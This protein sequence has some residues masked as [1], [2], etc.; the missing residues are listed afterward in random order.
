MED[1]LLEVFQ[2]YFSGIEKIKFTRIT[3]GHIHDTFHIE[4]GGGHIIQRINTRVFMDID[5]MMHNMML[6]SK[7][8]TGHRDIYPMKV[9]VLHQTLAGEPYYKDV[10]GDCWRLMTFIPGSFVYSK[11]I[12]GAHAEE[13]GKIL[14][15]FTS[16]V[17]GL[18]PSQF[19]IVIRD[20]H[21]INSRW[22]QYVKIYGNRLA[23]R[24]KET[25]TELRV[26]EEFNQP[27]QD[28]YHC[29]IQ[30]EYSRQGDAQ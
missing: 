7:F 23:E 27:M 18:D 15:I 30:W 26:A 24:L 29:L 4:N 3:G 12:D 1:K 16:A 19:N 17:T 25:R 22:D 9:P 14:G 5:G 8:L 2:H 21:N 28:Y 11:A 6:L 10:S 13:A 20:F